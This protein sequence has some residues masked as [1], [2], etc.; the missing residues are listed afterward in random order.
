MSFLPEP[1]Q[2]R[3]EIVYYDFK[4]NTI[5]APLPRLLIACLNTSNRFSASHTAL[6]AW[7]AQALMQARSLEGDA[8]VLEE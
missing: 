2:A 5:H 8:C 3:E 4:G 7:A 6:S 1:A